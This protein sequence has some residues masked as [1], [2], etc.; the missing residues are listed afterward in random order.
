MLFQSASLRSLSGAVAEGEFGDPDRAF[1]GRQRRHLAAGER[2]QGLGQGRGRT[3]G[4]GNRRIAHDR[5]H[6]VYPRKP[7]ADARKSAQKDHQPG[8]FS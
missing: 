6:P 1:G 5:A 7:R 8:A 2:P 3:A 4:L